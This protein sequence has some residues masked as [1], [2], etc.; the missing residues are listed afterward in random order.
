LVHGLAERKAAGL[1]PLTVISCDNLSENGHKLERAV[2]DFVQ[3]TSL[4][5]DGNTCFPNTMVDRITPATS[6]AVI[7]H[8]F[9]GQVPAWDAVGAEFTDNVAPFEMRKLRLLNASHSW[10]AYAGQL[11]GHTYVHEAIADPNLRRTVEQLWNEAQTTLPAV[12][13]P[14]TAA[15]R[16]ALIDRF[17][18]KDMRHELAQ[19]GADGSLKLRERIVPIITAGNAPQASE[20][21]AAWIAF[22]IKNIRSSLSF[23]DPNADQIKDVIVGSKNRHEICVRLADLIG[24]SDAPSSWLDTLVTQVES[25]LARDR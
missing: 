11:A 24:V 19:I 10:L 6:N 25:Y 9:A 7:E 12:V 1:P 2:Y 5:V 13:Q 17:A 21:V 8:K 22:C 3:A 14:T 4:T 20:A 23:V 15:Y 16:D 18:V